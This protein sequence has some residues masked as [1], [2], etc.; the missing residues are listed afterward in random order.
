MDLFQFTINFFFEM[1]DIE[2]KK[3]LT[4]MSW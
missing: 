4:G 1:G 3:N 2:K